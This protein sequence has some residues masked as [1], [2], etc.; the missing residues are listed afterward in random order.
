MQLKELHQC[1]EKRDDWTFYKEFVDE[2]SG[3]KDSRPQLLAMRGH[4]QQKRF[5]ILLV[6]AIDRLGRNLSQLVITLDD[7]LAW[8]IDFVSYTQP[9]D[10]T[11]PSGRFSFHM[12]AA[13]AQYERE[14]IKARVKAGIAQR[15]A[16]GDDFGRPKAEIDIIEAQ[17]RLDAGE[18]LTAIARDMGVHRSTLKRRLDG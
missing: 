1:I 4:A 8:G 2:I 15:I 13:L 17:E 5:D 6:W 12:L 16:R 11:V 7:L 10:V 18:T 3:A 9:I 14:M